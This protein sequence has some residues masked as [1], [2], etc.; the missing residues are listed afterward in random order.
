MYQGHVALP[1]EHRRND[2]AH[3]CLVWV[4]RSC[5]EVWRDDHIG[6]DT[7]IVTEQACAHARGRVS[8]WLGSPL[9]IFAQAE[10]HSRGETGA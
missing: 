5:Q 3:V 1:E 9:A 8:V 10:G 6:N 4:A 7:E 2:E